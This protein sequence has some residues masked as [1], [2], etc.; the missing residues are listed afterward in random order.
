MSKSFPNYQGHTMTAV[1]DTLLLF[2][3]KMK[4]GSLSNQ[5]WQYNISGETFECV[6][7]TFFLFSGSVSFRSISWFG[8]RIKCK[9]EYSEFSSAELRI[10]RIRVIFGSWIRF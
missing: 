6:L 2:G 8:S 3:G 4:N 9:K 10:G 1:G 7:S 5:L